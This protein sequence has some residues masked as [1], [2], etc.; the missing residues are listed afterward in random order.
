[1]VAG[2]MVAIKWEGVQLDCGSGS[3]V[4]ARGP[5]EPAGTPTDFCVIVLSN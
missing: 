1:M 3:T 5:S 4:I 2:G